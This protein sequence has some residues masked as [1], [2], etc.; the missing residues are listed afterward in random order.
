MKPIIESIIKNKQN[1]L[2]TPT[3][4]IQAANVEDISAQAK[5]DYGITAKTGV[6]LLELFDGGSAQYAGLLP[7]DVISR[8]NSKQVR[9]ISDLKS[10]LTNSKLNDVLMIDVNRNGTYKQVKVKLRE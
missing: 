4:G 1:Y 10:I 3:L 7:N 8:I 9:N 5:E 2:P 6:V